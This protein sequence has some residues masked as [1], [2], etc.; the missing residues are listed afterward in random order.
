MKTTVGQWELL[1][2]DGELHC[3]PVRTVTL[4]RLSW[5]PG[6]DSVAS[7]SEPSLTNWRAFIY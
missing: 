5:K 2:G 4:F 7:S 3:N 6:R 1:D